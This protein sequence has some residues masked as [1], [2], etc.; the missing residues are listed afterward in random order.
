MSDENVNPELNTKIQLDTKSKR[1]RKSLDTYANEFC[2][3]CKKCLRIIYGDR[4][5]FKSYSNIFKPSRDPS[6]KVLA[7]SLRNIGITVGETENYSQ[8]VCGPCGRKLRS[9]CETFT[10]VLNSLHVDSAKE[11][12]AH[13]ETSRSKRKVGDVITPDRFSPAN[14]K[15]CRQSSPV[16]SLARRSSRKALF[17]SNDEN[18]AR[19]GS[20]TQPQAVDTVVLAKLNIDDLNTRSGSAIKVVI[21]YPSGNITV[22]SNFDAAEKSLISNICLSQW[23]RAVG[24]IFRHPSLYDELLKYLEVKVDQEF[25]EYTRSESCLKATSTDQLAVFSNKIVCKEVSVYCPL[26]YS[27]VRGASARSHFNDEESVDHKATNAIALATSALARVKQP[28]M[29]ALAYRISTVLFHSGASHLDH[30]R[31]NHLGLCMSSQMV[32]SLHQKMGEK[33]DH[34]VRLWKKEIENNKS[35]QELVYDIMETQLPKR[36]DDDMDL[37][38]EVNLDEESIKELPSYNQQIYGHTLSLCEGVKRNMEEDCYTDEVLRQVE[39]ELRQT[40]LPTYK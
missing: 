5:S 1:G 33:F 25:I 36:S 18:N 7:D 8:A 35:A 4:T 24:A 31:L 37:D 20:K 39:K 32:I 3:L 40:P 34:K 6:C 19:E 13:G 21:A 26:Y 22:K 12:E 2:R 30:N 23:N 29:S 10:S 16:K 9:L 38:I 14:R 11:T 28:C 15:S 27:V 17:P